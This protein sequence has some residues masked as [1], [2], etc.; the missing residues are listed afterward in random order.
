MRLEIQFRHMD[1]SEALEALVTEKV[2]HAVEGFLHR[3]D[4]HIQIWLIS[5]L[6]LTTR[7]TGEFC[8]EIEIRYPKKKQLFI[9]KKHIDMHNAIQE[10][11]DTL[12]VL[13]D[14]AGKREL[15]HRHSREEVRAA[16]TAATDT[17]T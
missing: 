8:C 16:R 12:G 1:R 11:T 3:H 6:N 13:L 10:A 7:G 15:D 4:A 17:G 5:D 2:S 9:Q 14:E